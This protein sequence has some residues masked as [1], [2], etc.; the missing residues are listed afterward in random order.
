[1]DIVSPKAPLVFQTLGVK[2]LLKSKGAV[3]R[4][5]GLA[6]GKCE[7]PFIVCM[8]I[9]RQQDLFKGKRL[10]VGIEILF[11]IHV[12][13]EKV[14]YCEYKIVIRIARDMKMLPIAFNC[15]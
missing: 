12:C 11:W 15:E 10:V 13:I 2:A 4:K 1:M 14:M 9:G 8:Q 6:V 7:G 3:C 5:I